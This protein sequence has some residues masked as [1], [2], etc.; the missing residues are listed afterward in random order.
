MLETHREFARHGSHTLYLRDPGFEFT[1]VMLAKVASF[2]VRDDAGSW[3]LCAF[4]YSLLAAL[5]GVDIDEA[6]LLDAA[7]GEIITRIDNQT[8]VHRGE[9]TFEHRDGAFVEVLAPRWWV[10]THR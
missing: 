6:A 4:M 3:T 1:P 9:L 7:A 10:T 5:D 8:L 2:I